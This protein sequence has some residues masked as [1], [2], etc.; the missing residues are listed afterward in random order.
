MFTTLHQPAGS[1]GTNIPGPLIFGKRW[2]C[3]DVCIEA[4]T[5]P[6]D[7]PFDMTVLNDLD[8]FHPAIDTID[9]LPEI[10]N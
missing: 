3:S 7:E 9:R 8:R 1:P 4:I 10:R 5:R 2:G 6:R